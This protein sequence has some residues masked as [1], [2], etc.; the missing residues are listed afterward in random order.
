V[1]LAV[2]G[3]GSRGAALWWVMAVGALA[4]VVLVFTS[5]RLGYFTYECEDLEE[6][7]VIDMGERVRARAPQRSMNSVDQSSVSM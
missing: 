2:C 5:S 4:M 3:L 6:A 1:T 7:E